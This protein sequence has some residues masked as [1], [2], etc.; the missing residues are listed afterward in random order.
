M[1]KTIAIANP[2][3]GV[4]KTT[5][6]GSAAMCLT[7]RGWKVLAV[8]LDHQAS[9]TNWSGCKVDSKRSIAAALAGRCEPL[10]AI[11]DVGG[12][13]LMPADE[14]LAEVSFG[15]KRR[16]NE[17]GTLRGVLSKVEDSFDFILID[18]PPNLSQLTVNALVA[19]DGVIV[20]TDTAHLSGKRYAAL[21]DEINRMKKQENPD[22]CIIGVLLSRFDSRLNPSKIERQFSEGMGSV[23]PAAFFE[24][25]VRLST[26]VIESQLGW[27]G[28]GE[29]F[30]KS[31]I[32]AAKLD[33]ENFIGELLERIEC[34]NSKE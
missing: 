9:L 15:S 33:F 12:V 5:T 28:L 21:A 16:P 34:L 3:S 10:E 8:D 31:S 14:T 11:Q 32:C 17:R 6:A 20:P 26:A 27:C 18:T 4:G 7:Q 24:S 30:E 29:F 13:C 2:S 1:A 22:I 19:A 23:L 25:K